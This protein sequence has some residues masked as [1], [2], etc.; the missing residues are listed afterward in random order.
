MLCPYPA[1]KA[2]IHHF[3]SQILLMQCWYY[4]YQELCNQ[5]RRHCGDVYWDDGKWRKEAH[6]TG[7]TD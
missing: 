2:Q 4:F 5:A 1:E 3:N 6:E 7:I